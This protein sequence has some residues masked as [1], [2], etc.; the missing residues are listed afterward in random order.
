M[1]T[2]AHP[3]ARGGS[4]P[5]VSDSRGWPAGAGPSWDYSQ[6]IAALVSLFSGCFL[7]PSTQGDTFAGDLCG[8]RHKTCNHL[9]VEIIRSE[10]S[11]GSALPGS[12][13]AR[14]LV[15]EHRAEGPEDFS[16]RDR[17][18]SRGLRSHCQARWTYAGYVGPRI[19]RVWN[20]PSTP[21]PPR[22]CVLCNVCVVPNGTSPKME[23]ERYTK[24]G[25]SLL[26]LF[27]FLSW[28]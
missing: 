16:D 7:P 6:P 27:L 17:K 18:T 8:L 22:R 5:R 23:D 28:T 24:R 20:R 26:A 11:V 25:F 15:P 4:L 12:P 19:R 2:L 9:E 21:P 14:W 10:L 3:R 1:W 13:A